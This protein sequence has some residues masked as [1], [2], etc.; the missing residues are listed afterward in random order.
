MFPK[1]LE[2]NAKGF[3]SNM[4]ASSPVIMLGNTK[5]ITYTAFD[6]PLLS[7]M[8]LSSSQRWMQER[9][10]ESNRIRKIKKIETEGK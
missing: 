9:K 7:H 3:F 2:S 4:L 1:I 8:V 10:K 6:P 5:H